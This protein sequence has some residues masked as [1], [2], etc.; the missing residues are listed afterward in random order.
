MNHSD[1]VRFVNRRRF[2]RVP[3]KKQAFIAHFPFA[4]A[5]ESVCRPPEFVPAVV[6][7]L[8]GPGLRI[9]SR[10]EVKKGQRVLVVFGL[11][12]E[13]TGELTPTNTDTVKI[14]EDMGEVRHTKVI[15]DGLSIAVELTGLSDPDVDELILSLIHI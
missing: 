11:D 15:P 12:E 7:E 10:L 14:V 8:A 1:D 3:V 9:E 6:T 13:K 2:I 4:K 5:S